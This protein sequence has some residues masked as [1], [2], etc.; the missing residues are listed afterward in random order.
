M[1]GRSSPESA[2]FRSPRSPGPNRRWRVRDRTM[3]KIVAIGL[4]LSLSTV[5]GSGVHSRATEAAD[6]RSFEPV[7]A[8]PDAREYWASAT[9][10]GL[11]APNRAHDF[12]AYFDVQGVRVE[13]PHASRQA[14]LVGLTLARLGR[15]DSLRVVPEGEVVDRGEGRVEIRRDGLGVVEWFENSSAGL[16]QGFTLA[17]RPESR[18]ASAGASAPD[19]PPRDPLVV[20]L[21]VKGATAVGSG[22]SVLL[23]AQTGRSLEYGHLAVVDAKGIALASHFEVPTT[24]RI[25]IVVDDAAATYPIVIDPLLTKTADTRLESNV[26]N[27]FLGHSVAS[28]GDVNGDGYEDVISSRG[29]VLGVGPTAAYIHHG[30]PAGIA[31]GSLASAATV[32]TLSQVDTELKVA[33][34]GDVNGDGYDDVLVGS[35]QYNSG[36]GFLEGVAFLYL[37]GPSGVASGNES[38]AAARLEGDQ[39]GAGF[40]KSVASAG[41]VNGDGYADVI[42]GAPGYDNGQLDEGAAFVFL[43]SATGIA[44]GS[45][46]TAHARLESNQV[47]ASMGGS[48]ASAGDVNGDGRSDVIVGAGLYDDGQLDE[49]AAFVF[50]GTALGIANG[51]PLTAHARLESD[52]DSG[53]AYAAGAYV[54]GLGDVDGDGF[55]DVGLGLPAYNFKRG[56]VFVFK[57]SAAGLVANGSPANASA[58]LINP[59]LGGSPWDGNFGAGLAAGDL[60]GDGYADLMVGAPTYSLGQAGEGAI[61]TYLGSAS[62]IA[63]GGP[64]TSIVTLESN[65]PGTF[66]A[67]DIYTVGMGWALGV[68]DTNGD[69]FADLIAGLE[70]YTVDQTEEGAV[71]VYR[72]GSR[73]F[74]RAAFEP[75]DAS[76]GGIINP[77][78]MRGVGHG[79]LYAV[80]SVAGDVNGDGFGDVIMSVPFA[81]TQGVI[82]SGIALVYN[83]SPAGIG[84]VVIAQGSLLP[85]ALL[86][87][88]PPGS[89]SYG[90]LV[91][92]AGDVNGDGYG[93]VL[94]AAEGSVFL[95]LGSSVGILHDIPGISPAP[96]NARFDILQAGSSI[97]SMGSAGDVNGDGY[98]DFILGFDAYD[99]GEVDEGAAFLFLGGATIANGSSSSAN[100]R[101]EGNQ[102]NARLGQRVSSAGDVNGDGFDDILVTAP[103]SDSGQLGEGATFLFLGSAAGIPNGSPATAHV[104][105]ESDVAFTSDHQ[106]ATSAGDVN[107]DGYSDVALGVH[108]YDTGA[109]NQ[110]EGAVFVFHGSASGITNGHAAAADSHVWSSIANG[111]LG[112]IVTA[113]GDLD[114]DGFGDL[115][116]SGPSSYI[117]GG[118]PLGIPTGDAAI[119]A[120]SSWQLSPAVGPIDYADVN[121]DGYPDALSTQSNSDTRALAKVFPG[122]SIGRLTLVK[123]RRND[124]PATLV[125]PGGTVVASSGFTAELF[126]RSPRGRE[127]AKLEVEL[128]PA[129]IAFGNAACTKQQTPNWVDLGTTDVALSTSLTNL[130]VNTRYAWRARTLFAA[131]SA[132]Q[133]GITPIVRRG[134]WFRPARRSGAEDFRTIVPEP[135]GATGLLVGISLL[136]GMARRRE[137]RSRCSSNCR[138]PEPAS[139]R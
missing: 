112:V 42:V 133:P 110:D 135:T 107:G 19:A 31:N 134:P 61:F 94:V 88:Y 14:P 72:G 36:Q 136:W 102:A 53:G 15:T 118:S 76:V 22:D 45:P 77:G 87:P 131:S 32:L 56:A 123:Q 20:E 54:A 34:A 25:R 104:R 70:R 65:Q 129:Q 137:G 39:T 58:S 138:W 97:S 50:L 16:E 82:D 139:P 59:T 27:G 44:N 35:A 29:N 28:A 95:R 11:Q 52:N 41:D 4:V 124:P 80:A 17:A 26:V 85:S 48:V 51:N 81:D 5:L 49:G 92:G 111:H 37:G 64:S 109:L 126:A 108:Q 74:V 43:G 115:S 23:A 30:G 7:Q 84:P 127:R 114:G 101:F 69:G 6:A 96:A 128:C 21:T 12:R 106:I 73:R 40:G 68:G 79:S 2:R 105:I 60:N 10:Q 8:P 33:S 100:A 113:L 86:M 132:N 120:P 103:G 98:D 47:R 9:K 13:D 78:E 130:A 71:L 18:T 122:N 62:G 99:A 57:G 63:S 93:D 117:L 66:T 90:I 3:E 1:L 91:S 125:S 89:G 55:G 119:L 67:E 38:A 83:G 46:A 75:A 121:G 116:V 24:D